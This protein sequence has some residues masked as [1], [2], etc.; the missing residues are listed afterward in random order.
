MRFKGAMYLGQVLK[1]GGVRQRVYE[2]SGVLV[3]AFGT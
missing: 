2:A 1:V 3:R